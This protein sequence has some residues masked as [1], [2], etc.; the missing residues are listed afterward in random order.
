MISQQEN[1]LAVLIAFIGSIDFT[2]HTKGTNI[3]HTAPVNAV[4]NIHGSLIVLLF[5]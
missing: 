3:F 4:Y 2:N 5:N 1:F